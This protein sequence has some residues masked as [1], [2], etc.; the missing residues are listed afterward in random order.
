MRRALIP[1]VAGVAA[2][3]LVRLRST[4]GPEHL[5]YY[6]SIGGRMSPY[7]PEGILLPKLCPRGGFAFAAQLA[8]SDGSTARA[9]TVVPCPRK[10]R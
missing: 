9:S 2:V 8:F 5:T 7:T 1:V 10:M 4:L 6:R 3:A